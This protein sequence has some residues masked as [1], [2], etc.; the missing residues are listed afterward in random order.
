MRADV[1]QA[2]KTVLK[3]FDDGVFIRNVSG[4]VRPEWMLKL[5]PVLQA[6]AVLQKAA[7]EEPLY[8]QTLLDALD[9]KAW[10]TDSNDWVVSMDD[11]RDVV[12]GVKEPR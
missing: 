5:V 6:L 9:S 8:G 11:V 10:S 1:R 12:A 2:L 7:D 3:A 4:D